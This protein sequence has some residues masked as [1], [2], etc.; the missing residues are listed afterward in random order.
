MM[1]DYRTMIHNEI[2]ILS[3]FVLLQRLLDKDDV[4]NYM[5]GIH[6]LDLLIILFLLSML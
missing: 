1:S 3:I 6:F 5:A 2:L 4:Q